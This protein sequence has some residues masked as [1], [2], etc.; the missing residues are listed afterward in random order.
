MEKTIKRTLAVT[1]AADSSSPESFA[2][3]STSSKKNKFLQSWYP[4]SRSSDI[5]NG[6]HKTIKIFSRDWLLFRTDTGKIS[7]VSRY[8]CHMGADLDR[9]KVVK[10]T[11]ECPLHA[12][13]FDASGRCV[14]IPGLEKPLPK[15]QLYQLTC[16]EKHGLV[17]VFWGPQPLF[18]IPSPPDVSEHQ[19]H[20]SVRTQ[21][22]NSGYQVLSLNA[23]DTQHLKH[24]HN[25]V[26]REKP[27]IDIF[28]KYALRM[29]SK[30]EVFKKKRIIDYIIS[31]L[32]NKNTPITTECWGGSLVTL[33]NHDLKSSA[34][35]ALRPVDSETTK[36]YLVSITEQRGKMSIFQKMKLAISV[37]LLHNFLKADLIPIDNMKLHRAGLLDDLDYGVE[38]YWNHFESMPHFKMPQ[39]DSGK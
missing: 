28:Q 7:F 32:G 16:E 39:N 19:S 3:N 23:F 30:P 18:D 34:L 37:R 38:A 20:S 14:D 8:C 27:V 31:L 1:T 5:K 9:G 26:F 35:V 11:I 13:R 4:V 36:V 25:R 29:K 15:R 12:W 2:L 6:Q 33:T 10:E 22:L 24:V 17:F 21:M